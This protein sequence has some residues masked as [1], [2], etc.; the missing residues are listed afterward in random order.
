ML[1]MFQMTQCLKI[2]PAMRSNIHVLSNSSKKSYEKYIVLENVF[3]NSSDIYGVKNE[4]SGTFTSNQVV[5]KAE[6][7][8]VFGN[9]DSWAN[10]ER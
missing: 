10:E 2:Y 5:E 8:H 3:L 1:T 4:N 9:S 7:A 6:V